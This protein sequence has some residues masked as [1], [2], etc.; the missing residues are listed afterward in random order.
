[1]A[2]R[3]YSNDRSSV[4]AR[5]SARDALARAALRSDCREA[6]RPPES[7]PAPDADPRLSGAA[8]TALRGCCPAPKRHPPLPP[9]MAVIQR[10]GPVAGAVDADRKSPHFA[11]KDLIVPTR[12]RR[13][14]PHRFFVQSQ[15]LHHAQHLLLAPHARLSLAR[16]ASHTSPVRPA[17]R[18][19]VAEPRGRRAG[20][21]LRREKPTPSVDCS[22][23]CNESLS[24]LL[25][26]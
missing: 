26:S 11:V 17:G 16:I 15:S 10:E 14:L 7:Q 2:T 3:L 8:R 20:Q 22:V 25:S 5:G 12:F 23:N 24:C 21:W 1:M 6:V 9:G 18:R 4:A 19:K 13:R